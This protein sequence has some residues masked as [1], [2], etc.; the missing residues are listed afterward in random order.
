MFLSRIMNTV[1]LYST[2]FVLPLLGGCMSMFPICENETGN[3]VII[4]SIEGRPAAGTAGG[5]GYLSGRTAGLSKLDSVKGELGVNMV[6]AL[7]A[8]KQVLVDI[9]YGYCR[10]DNTLRRQKKWFAVTEDTFKFADGD[11]ACI[12]SNFLGNATL[13]VC[14]DKTLDKKAK[15]A[16]QA[17][18]AS[19]P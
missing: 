7:V 17:A 1:S 6:A 8:P 16:R 5:L 19:A 10:K 14:N 4:H 2:I 15:A 3:E 13:E 12:G 9:E 18:A 11:H